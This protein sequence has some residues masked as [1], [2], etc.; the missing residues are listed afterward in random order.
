[1]GKK[2]GL[3]KVKVLRPFPTQEIRDALKNANVILVPEF[4][5]AGWMHKEICSIMYGHS[6]AKIISG[7]RV[8]GGMTMPTEM[9]LEW[10]KEHV[11]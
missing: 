8:Y 5:H 3:I 10:L 7:P 4:N 6:D 1:M 9:I 2:V 11:K